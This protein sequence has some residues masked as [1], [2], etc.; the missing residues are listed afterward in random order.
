MAP[1]TPLVDPGTYFRRHDRPSL[2]VAA[3]VVSVQAAAISVAMW[4]F[5]QRVIAHVEAPPEEKAQ[6]QGA[7]VGATVG[8]F[9]AVFFGWLVLAAILHAFVWFAGGSRGFGTTLAVT[10]EAELTGLVLLPLTAVGLFT[11]LGQAPSDPA[12]FTDFFE[13]ATS[14]SSPVL[15]VSSLLGMLWTAA[16]QGF[17]LAEAH[18]LP[19][20]KMLALAFVVGGVGFLLN[21]L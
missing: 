1:S 18:D 12:A 14:F 8:V 6:A 19:V 16:I 13:R 10:G 15:L 2:A 21:L 9:V 20:E 11:L 4:L 17:G 7:L 3:G 5:L